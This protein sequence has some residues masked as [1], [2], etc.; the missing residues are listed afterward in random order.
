MIDPVL[1]TA[2]TQKAVTLA[3]ARHQLRVVDHD[4]DDRIRLL[5]V[6]ATADYEAATGRVVMESTWE[7]QTV[8]FHSSGM[9]LRK[10]PFQAITSIK[11]IDTAD[12]EQT[13]A[14]SVYEAF[15]FNSRAR[16]LLQPD[17]EW[18]SDVRSKQDAVRIRYTAGHSVTTAGV[19]DEVKH[20][21]LLRLEA[22]YDP[23]ATATAAAADRFYWRDMGNFS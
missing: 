18:P 2:N 13:V 9:L 16:V 22:I 11:Y 17:E 3:E 8:A 23:E 19:P 1:I 5:I 21:I 4:E 7:E 12:V 15:V 10:S 20:A 14:T 6:A